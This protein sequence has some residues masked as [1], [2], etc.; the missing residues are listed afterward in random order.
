MTSAVTSPRL[1]LLNAPVVTDYGDWRFEG[2]LT[3]DQ[4]REL[5]RGGFI[6]AIGH[7]STAAL[8]STLLQV[9]VRAE[10]L[11]VSMAPGD[12][13]LVFRVH[14]RLPEAKVLTEEE[15]RAIGYELGVLTRLT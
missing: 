3:L 1:Y 4:A 13:A 8:L 10:R 9:P 5:V 12:R 6:S 7:E 15:L 11:T 14:G 2:P